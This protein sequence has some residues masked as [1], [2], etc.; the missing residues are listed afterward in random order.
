M[1]KA[2]IGSL[3]ALTLALPL[4]GCNKSPSTEAA[5]APAG[6][7]TG[8]EAKAPHPTP[9]P[10]GAPVDV[11]GVARAEGGKTVAEVFAEKDSLAGQPV[12]LRGKVVKSN[13]GIMGKNWIHVRDGSG[14]DG[15]NDLTVTTVTAQP[16][17]GDTVVITGP[18]S[19]NKD[20]G[21]GYQYDVIVEDAQVT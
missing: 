1:S 3:L 2:M 19:L 6:M 20:F 12:T 5:Q 17:V 4:A 11:S 9:A 21:M 18:V 13:T 10:A 15:S 7:A 8:T 16:N 14:S